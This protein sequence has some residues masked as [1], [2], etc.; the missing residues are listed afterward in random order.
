MTNAALVLLVALTAT[1]Y[2]S[3][4]TRTLTETETVAESFL[5]KELGAALGRY[6]LN[7]PHGSENVDFEFFRLLKLPSQDVHHPKHSRDGSVPI[8]GSLVTTDGTFYPFRTASLRT[9]ATGEYEDI[10]FVTTMI[11]GVTY[12]FKGKFLEK[13]V[14]EKHGGPYTD[15]RGVI[16]KNEKGKLTSS[17]SLPFSAFPEL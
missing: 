5:P 3:A 10:E 12:Q 7:A 8:S 1:I 9:R 6:E 15:L 17:K 11:H 13:I 2:T 16:T 14:Q 4:Q